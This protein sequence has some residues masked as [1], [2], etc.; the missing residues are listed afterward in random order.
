MKKQ[1][2]LMAILLLGCSLLSSCR[3]C[4]FEY[5]VMIEPSGTVIANVPELTVEE[6]VNIPA[7]ENPLINFPMTGTP[8][9]MLSMILKSTEA[10]DA[11]KVLTIAVAGDPGAISAWRAQV[12]VKVI[13]RKAL[14]NF[15]FGVRDK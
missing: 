5:T 9:D 10:V 14:L 15:S 7:V 12:P 1:L 4:L 2:L 11:A 3:F 8:Y 13:E 6:L